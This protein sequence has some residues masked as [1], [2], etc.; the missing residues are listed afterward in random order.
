MRKNSHLHGEE[1]AD[2]LNIS[3]HIKIGLPQFGVVELS[4]EI[5]LE[6]KNKDISFLQVLIFYY[7]SPYQQHWLKC[8]HDLLIS[9]RYQLRW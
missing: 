1:Q 3:Q 4:L 7:L 6:M 5:Y 8:T 9:A 2:W